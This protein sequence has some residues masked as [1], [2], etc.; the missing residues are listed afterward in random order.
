MVTKYSGIR[1]RG[2]SPGRDWRNAR[3][4]TARTYR[5][6]DPSVF[7]W[8]PASL[9]HHFPNRERWTNVTRRN[10]WTKI[11]AWSDGV[12]ART[13]TR[14]QTEIQV[15][16]CHGFT[17]WQSTPNSQKWPDLLWSRQREWYDQTWTGQLKRVC[18][19]KNGKTGKWFDWF[20]LIREVV[21]FELI[22]L[23]KCFDLIWFDLIMQVVWFEGLCCLSI[24]LWLGSLH[25]GRVNGVICS[26]HDEVPCHSGSTLL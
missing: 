24:R 26:Q 23:S 12:Y 11:R 5:H 15:V 9:P 4:F 21:L 20:D 25:A 2:I 3:L 17:V 18:E 6:S 14:W 13:R 1:A 19:K 10:Y 22:W 8:S 16:G 7:C